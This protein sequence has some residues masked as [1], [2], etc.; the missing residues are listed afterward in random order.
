MSV[1]ESTYGPLVWDTW[2]RSLFNVPNLLGS[3]QP[4][5]QLPS[6]WLTDEAEVRRMSL[7]FPEVTISWQY[8]AL[9]SSPVGWSLIS[10]EDIWKGPSEDDLFLWRRDSNEG[11]AHYHF[12]VYTV[13]HESNRPI[14]LPPNSVFIFP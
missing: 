1:N 12:N 7:R 2:C 10:R 8:R 6:S 5:Y 14:S 13:I 4:N 3:M 9:I 11:P